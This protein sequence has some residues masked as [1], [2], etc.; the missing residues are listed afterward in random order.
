V[1]KDVHGP[2]LGSFDE[3]ERKKPNLQGGLL[4]QMDRRAREVDLIKKGGFIRSADGLFGAP[5]DSNN[6]EMFRQHMLAQER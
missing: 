6:I 2:L 3:V 4:G 1:K 5:T